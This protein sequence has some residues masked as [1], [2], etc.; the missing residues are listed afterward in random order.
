[1]DDSQD[2]AEQPSEQP[3]VEGGLQMVPFDPIDA[4]SD[5]GWEHE[6]PNRPDDDPNPDGQEEPPV[7]AASLAKMHVHQIWDF[8]ENI[9]SSVSAQ[10]LASVRSKEKHGGSKCGTVVHWTKKN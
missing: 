5:D 10:S 1:M 9:T 4:D 7:T 8:L 6:P 3:A 2:G